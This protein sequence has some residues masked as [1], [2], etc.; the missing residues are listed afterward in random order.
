M[1]WSSIKRIAKIIGGFLLLLIGIV[2][3]PLPGPGWV[4]IA[5]GL[6]V[7]ANEYVWAR[8]LLDRLKGVGERLRKSLP[9]RRDTPDSSGRAG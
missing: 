3:V 5:L 2:L 8:A 6:A 9:T 4:V 7:L 1:T